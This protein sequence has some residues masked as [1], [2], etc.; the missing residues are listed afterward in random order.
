M[1]VAN[2]RTESM[3]SSEGFTCP[4]KEKARPVWSEPEILRTPHLPSL[5]LLRLFGFGG[6]HFGRRH[7]LGLRL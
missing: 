3:V 2:R 6:F 7:N 4:Q 5:G 1:F